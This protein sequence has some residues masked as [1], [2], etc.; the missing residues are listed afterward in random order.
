MQEVAIVWFIVAWLTAWLI[1]LVEVVTTVRGPLL[2]YP[3]LKFIVVVIALAIVLR[4]LS[5]HGW[6]W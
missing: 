5:R 2:I 3:I 6:F 4:N 1:D